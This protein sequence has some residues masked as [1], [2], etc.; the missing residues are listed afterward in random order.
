[1]RYKCSIDRGAD[2]QILIFQWRVA[3]GEVYAGEK[4]RKF[5]EHARDCMQDVHAYIYHV[6]REDWETGCASAGY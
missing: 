2:F 5:P 6:R 1:M 3:G 4:V